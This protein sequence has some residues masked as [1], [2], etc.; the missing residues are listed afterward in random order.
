MPVSG[1]RLLTETRIWRDVIGVL[2]AFAHKFFCPFPIPFRSS[3]ASLSKLHTSVTA[4][5]DACVCMYV[6]VWP[7]TEKFKLSERVS[8][9]HTCYNKC[10][11]NDKL[12]ADESATANHERQGQA[13]PDGIV[14]SPIVVAF[15]SG[16]GH[17]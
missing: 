13:V 6:C 5:L 9:L 4:I 3:G 15:A 7:Y 16:K 1:P 8:N 12:H 17:A 11:V 14:K 10:S 2:L